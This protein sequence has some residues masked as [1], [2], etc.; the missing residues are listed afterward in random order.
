MIPV[1][2]DV[3]SL[4]C[5]H[6]EMFWNNGADKDGTVRVRRN[7]NVEISCIVSESA[8]DGVESTRNPRAGMP[9][10]EAFAPVGPNEAPNRNIWYKL[11]NRYCRRPCR[12]AGTFSSPF[13]VPASTVTMHLGE[14][15][16]LVMS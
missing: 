11:Y 13:S 12:V 7:W 9:P 15:G 5:Q 10:S 1:A 2:Q 6:W 14:F 8:R 16:G 3:S 4:Y